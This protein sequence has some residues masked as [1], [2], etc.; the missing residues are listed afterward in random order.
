M[1]GWLREDKARQGKG[2]PWARE[3]AAPFLSGVS[4]A[5]TAAASVNFCCAIFNW[6]KF[7]VSSVF[8]SSSWR[9]RE[10]SCAVCSEAGDSGAPGAAMVAGRGRCGGRWGCQEKSRAR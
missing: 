8:S 9:S 3:R 1:G 6:L 5:T 10:R 7:A 4:V 2:A